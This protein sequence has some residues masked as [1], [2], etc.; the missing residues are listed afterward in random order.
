MKLIFNIGNIFNLGAWSKKHFTS[1]YS[2]ALK[3]IDNETKIPNTK[4]RNNKNK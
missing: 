3:R 2:P 1:V 4:N